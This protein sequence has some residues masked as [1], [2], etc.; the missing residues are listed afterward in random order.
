MKNWRLF[1]IFLVTMVASAQGVYN[2][3]PPPGITYSTAAGMTLGSPTGG[4]CGAGC[5]NAAAIEIN[6]SPQGTVT[7]VSVATANGFTGSVANPTTTPAITITPNFTG[8]AYSNG[9]VVAAAIAAN[10][11]TLNQTTT[12]QSGTALALAATPTLCSSG[13]AAQGILANGNATGCAV[14]PSVGT[15]TANTVYAGPT[16]GSPATPTF[17]AL[18]TNDIPSNL[19]LGTTVNGAPISTCTTGSFAATLTGFSGTAPTGTIYYSLCGQTVWIYVGVA[20]S[21]LGTSNSTAMSISGAP[22]IILPS[23]Q[24][25]LGQCTWLEDNGTG[26]IVGVIGPNTSTLV[27]GLYAISGSYIQIGG[28]FTASGTKGLGLDFSCVYSL[29]NP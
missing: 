26:G 1:A 28:P 19:N 11:P 14:N 25:Q 7:S 2:Y 13:Q 15:E 21:I 8:I 24:S 5:L 20:K 17:R 10:F 4:S 23:V 18:V 12:G 9:S 29:P 3:F 27:L 16:A 6:G 22:S